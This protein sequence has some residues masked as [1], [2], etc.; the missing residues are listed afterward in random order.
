MATIRETTRPSRAAQWALTWKNARDP[1][2]T[3]TGGDATSA[4]RKMFPPNGAYVCV[5]VIARTLPAE[6]GP[7]KYRRTSTLSIQFYGAERRTRKIRKCTAV[8]R[9]PVATLRCPRPRRADDTPRCA[10]PLRLAPALRRVRGARGGAGRR[11]AVLRR[12]GS[13][14]PADPDA[15]G[16]AGS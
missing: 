2:R 16:R 13:L 10:P 7:R 3:T 6:G 11:A 1:S 14:G 9:G 8:D 4:E 5:H 12:P 15:A